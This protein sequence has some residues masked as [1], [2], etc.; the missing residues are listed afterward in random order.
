MLF[1]IQRY[2]PDVHSLREFLAY[3][4]NINTLVFMIESSDSVNGFT[5]NEIFKLVYDH[6]CKTIRL[7]IKRGEEV[8]YYNFANEQLIRTTIT[9]LPD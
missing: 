5:S 3:F 4:I 6:I 1:P 7:E 8:A 2:I 9:V